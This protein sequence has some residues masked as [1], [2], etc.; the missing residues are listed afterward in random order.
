MSRKQRKPK[1][2]TELYAPVRRYLAEQGYAVR[3]EVMGC[4]I[5]ATRDDELVVVEMKLRFGVDLLI[6]AIQRQKVADAVYV[7]IP[8]PDGLGWTRKWR[9]I[10]HMLRRLELGLILVSFS[11]RRANVEVK[12]HPLPFT[13]RRQPQKRQAILREAAARTGDGNLGGSSGKKLLTAYRERAIHAAVCLEALGEASPKQLR[14]LG[15]GA[16]ARA[17][18]YDNHYGWFE[19]IGR[20]RYRLSAAGAAALDTY[21]EPVATFREA[22]AKKD[23]QETG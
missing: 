6:Q 1:R 16:K 20:G 11:G 15:V 10:E 7:A 13:R 22:L 2:E 12:L 17:I 23:A 18:L 4:D 14:D 21:P 9:G 19:R 8:R 3:S 5:T